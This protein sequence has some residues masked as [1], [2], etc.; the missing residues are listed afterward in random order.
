MVKNPLANAGDVKDLSLIP[1][2]GRSFE[3]RLGPVF[4]FLSLFSS[5]IRVNQD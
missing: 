3:G 1:G 4:F 2:L 5:I